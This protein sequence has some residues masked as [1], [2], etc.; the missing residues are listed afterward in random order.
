[1]KTRW[2]TIFAAALGLTALLLCSSSVRPT[3]TAPSTRPETAQHNASLARMP[4][5]PQAD[6]SR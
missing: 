2:L 5:A 3:P 1:M 4:P 6:P